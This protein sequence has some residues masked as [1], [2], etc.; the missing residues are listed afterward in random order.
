M[1]LWTGPEHA[2]QFE[3]SLNDLALYF[4]FQP[5]TA[6]GADFHELLRYKP[7]EARDYLRHDLR[8]TYQIAEAMHA[9]KYPTPTPVV[10]SAPEP[11]SEPET[12]QELIKF[13]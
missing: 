5:K 2:A 4:G 6:N 7:D 12:V 10:Q 9:L 8:L 1:E 13:Y 11:E 3:V